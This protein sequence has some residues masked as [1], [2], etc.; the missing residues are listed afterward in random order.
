MDT[1]DDDDY[2]DKGTD[3]Y[4]LNLIHL[5]HYLLVY[6]LALL[7]LALTGY[8]DL[9]I[10]SIFIMLVSRR[11]WTIEED[12]AIR[13]L[14]SQ[15]GTK[16]WSVIADHIVKGTCTYVFNRSKFIFFDIYTHNTFICRLPN[17]MEKW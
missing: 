5:L 1:C 11:V 12:N 6:L 13:G 8:I 16:S 3:R 2:K 7:V 17:S 10:D 4:S 15:Y 9:C 14:V